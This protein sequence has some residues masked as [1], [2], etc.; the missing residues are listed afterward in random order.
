[1]NRNWKILGTYSL[2]TTITDISIPSNAI[3]ILIFAGAINEANNQVFGGKSYTIP[4]L[5][6][7]LNVVAEKEIYDA[8][9]NVVATNL[10]AYLYN[11]KLAAS[12]KTG[13]ARMRLYYR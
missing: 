2:S 4:I 3:E 7:A 12:I 1:M 10:Y 9:F 5:E 6:S 8:A 11:Y 13:S